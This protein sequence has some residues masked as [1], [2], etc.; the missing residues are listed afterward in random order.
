MTVA[1]RPERI[2]LS[3]TWGDLRGTLETHYYLGDVNDCRVRVGDA[4][5][6]VI[7]PPETYETMKPKDTV[8]LTFRE[9][10]VFEDDGSLDEK[11]KIK[12]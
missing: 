10:M 8:Y 6:R 11:L 5:F 3:L 4:T 9:E 7:A 2:T 12:T 1:V